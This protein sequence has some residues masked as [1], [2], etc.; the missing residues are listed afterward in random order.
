MDLLVK[1]KSEI[2]YVVKFDVVT[3]NELITTEAVVVEKLP[4]NLVMPGRSA[5]VK[6]HR[7]WY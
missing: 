4:D 2:Y 3:D 1:V 7:S 5:I 6:E